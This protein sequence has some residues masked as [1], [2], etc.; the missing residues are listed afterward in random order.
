MLTTRSK[1]RRSA[2]RRSH[3]EPG[4]LLVVFALALT[5]V[6]LAVG[7]VVDGGYAWAQRRSAQ[8]AAD[9][10][11]LAGT[12]IVGL[13]LAGS[14]ADGTTVLNAMNAVNQANGVPN[15]TSGEAIYVDN[16]GAST[17]T[18]VAAGAIPASARGVQLSASRQWRPFFLG[19]AGINSWTATASAVS[20]TSIKRIDTAPSGDLL[21]LAM[22]FN[23]VPSIVCPEG[24]PASSCTTT[25]LASGTGPGQFGWMS[26][27]GAGNAV[28][29]CDIM[30]PPLDNPAYSIALNSYITIPGNTG[31][32]ASNCL[33][34]AFQYWI[35]SGATIYVPIISPG[36][37]A[38]PSFCWPGTAIQYPDPTNGKTGSNIAYNVI[39]FG[40]FQMTGCDGSTD[41]SKCKIDDIEG[42]YRQVIFN[43]PTGAGEPG[44][45]TLTGTAIQ[46]VR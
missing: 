36:P 34:N 17:G 40:G 10:A 15:V 33:R 35:D 1:S 21:P 31:V 4:Q 8:N 44:G 6:V 25:T 9:L 41:A 13:K 12:R 38:C 30:T 37:G 28:Y 3:G 39:G 18:L 32:S 42:V 45:S 27:S 11:S 24:T 5:G 43:G 2:G 46:L 7:L 23:S 22:P 26:W 20:K 29:T 16:N 14:T 19:M